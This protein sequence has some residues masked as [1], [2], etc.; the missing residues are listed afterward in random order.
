MTMVLPEQSS[1]GYGR[2]VNCPR[3]MLH[4]EAMF[5]ATVCFFKVPGLFESC[6]V[7]DLDKEGTGS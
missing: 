2:V 1:S 7:I 3:A 6:N 5:K 4:T